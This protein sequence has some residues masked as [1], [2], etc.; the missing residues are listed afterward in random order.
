MP[1]DRSL[2]SMVRSCGKVNT[3]GV[4]ERVEAPEDG[5]EEQQRYL[6]HQTQNIR[7]SCLVSWTS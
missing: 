1:E 5:E 6:K 3:D 4:V 2:I 7:H